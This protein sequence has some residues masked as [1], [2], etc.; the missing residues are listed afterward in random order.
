MI[1]QDG[2]RANVGIILA[3]SSGQLLWARRIGQD[4]WQFP[5]GGMDLGETPEQA[6][7]RELHEEVGLKPEHVKVLG[8]TS[9][10]LRYHLPRRYIR[11]HQRPLCV[12]QKQKWFLLELIADES[13][14]NLTAVP[15]HEFDDY[16]WVS[17]WFPLTQVID[18]KRSVYQSAMLELLPLLPLDQPN[19]KRY[20]EPPKSA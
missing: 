18:F 8:V 13:A 9:G 16:A 3:N 14:I 2:F 5:Q 7:F 17:Y 15:P 4:S 1:D 12:G 11:Q 10:W 20:A 19:F 6:M